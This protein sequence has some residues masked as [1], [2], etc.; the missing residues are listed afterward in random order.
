LLAL[1]ARQTSKRPMP[2]TNS[3]G[4]SQQACVHD[5][6]VWLLAASERSTAQRPRAMLPVRPLAKLLVRIPG[7]LPVRLL[8]RL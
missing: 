1:S 2:L 6:A 8:V 3:M 7:R 4:W 5:V